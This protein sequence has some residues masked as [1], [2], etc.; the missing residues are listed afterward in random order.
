MGL[1][2]KDDDGTLH[3]PF[4]VWIAIKF[5]PAPWGAIVTLIVKILDSLP[6]AQKADVVQAYANAK[7]TGDMTKLTEAVHEAATQQRERD[8]VR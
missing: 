2:P 4:W 5:V 8:L 3:I 6:V 7:M 1:F